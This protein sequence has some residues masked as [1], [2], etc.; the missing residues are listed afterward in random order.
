[1]KTITITRKQQDK[2]QTLGFITIENMD[3]LPLFA[4]LVLERGWRNNKKGKSCIPCGEYLIVL[5]KSAR[6]NTLLWEVKG[7]KNRSECK[8]HASNYWYQINGCMAPGLKV[9]DINKDGYQDVTASRTALAALHAAMGND[10]QAKI[11]IKDDPCIVK[12]L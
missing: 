8:I 5:E 6:F 4:S 1:M 11:I 2:N 7:V 9:K 12:S 10:T 3:G